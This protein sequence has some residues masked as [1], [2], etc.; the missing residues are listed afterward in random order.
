MNTEVYKILRDSKISKGLT[1]DE[2]F[3]LITMWN[4]DILSSFF[5]LLEKE[6]NEWKY[7]EN[8]FL[9]IKKLFIQWSWETKKAQKEYCEKVKIANE[10]CLKDF[11]K[12]ENKTAEKQLSDLKEIEDLLNLTK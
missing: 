8:E 6:F 5:E 7:T 2:L 12:E 9:R 4:S 10:K 1:E 11:L 3:L